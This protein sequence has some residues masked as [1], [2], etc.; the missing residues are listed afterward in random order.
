MRRASQWMR[1]AGKFGRWRPAVAIDC[2]CFLRFR[3]AR[4]FE[5][6]MAADGTDCI[7]QNKG[8]SA[9][10]IAHHHPFNGSP[11][12]TSAGWKSAPGLSDGFIAFRIPDR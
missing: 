12:T 2:C 9:H 6:W 5:P 8:Q 7:L 11:I 3:L 1:I 4:H 10:Y